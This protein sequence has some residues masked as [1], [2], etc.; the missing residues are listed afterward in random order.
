VRR[1]RAARRR[2][3]ALVA[4]YVAL[5]HAPE[6]AEV[7]IAANDPQQAEDRVYSDL[8]RSVRAN[9]AIEARVEKQAVAL[10]ERRSDLPDR[11]RRR[12]RRGPPPFARSVL[13]VWRNGELLVYCDHGPEAWRMPWQQ[14]PRAE[15]RV[16]RTSA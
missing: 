15:G 9:A 12:A 14:G 6:E 8:R 5:V 7:L 10:Q 11:V 16:A 13:P 4:L 2:I 1:R 3:A